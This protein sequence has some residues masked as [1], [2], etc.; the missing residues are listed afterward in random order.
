MINNSRIVSPLAT[1]LLS[2]YAVA[3]KQNSNNSSLA[4]VSASS[5]EGDFNVT[6]NSAVSFLDEPAKSITLG[7]SVTAATIFFVPA[8]SYEGIKKTGAELTISGSVDADG[9]TLYKAVLDSGT[10]T[11]TK[12]GL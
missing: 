11:I 8:F 4:K 10:V 2:I 9:S 12:E 3:L 5:V 6:T 7:T 1:D